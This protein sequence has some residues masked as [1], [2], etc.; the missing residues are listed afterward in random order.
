M[1]YQAIKFSSDLIKTKNVLFY[2]IYS[3][4]FLIPI[5]GFIVYLPALF[6][7]GIVLKEN[8]IIF[9]MFYLKKI[10][11]KY[12]DIKKISTSL[13]YERIEPG[14][15]PDRY[16][17]LEKEGKKK[18]YKVPVSS[19]KQCDNLILFDELMKRF[20]DMVKF[21]PFQV[22]NVEDTF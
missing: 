19:F 6:N 2:F 7:W 3:F 21:N 11:I 16:I 4:S 14:S 15:M 9:N 12:E 10:E 13:D 18:P 8:S 5:F 22:K 17:E 1:L 20:P